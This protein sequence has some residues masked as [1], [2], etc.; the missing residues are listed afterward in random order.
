[1]VDAHAYSIIAAVEVPLGQKNSTLGMFSMG[2]TERLV[3]IR[4]PWGFREWSGDWS[5]MS[6]LWQIYPEAK[7]N[8]EKALDERS[9]SLG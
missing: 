4:N 9:E 2:G 5:D 6:E 8:I 7:R 1:M 3:L